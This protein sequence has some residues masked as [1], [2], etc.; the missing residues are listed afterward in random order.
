MVMTTRATMTTEQL[1]IAG[2]DVERITV[3]CAHG[4]ST[5]DLVNGRL[6]GAPDADTVARILAER[7]EAEEGCGCA[8]PLLAPGTPA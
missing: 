1:R 3:D 6:P 7:H 4:T 5:A 2:V 8:L